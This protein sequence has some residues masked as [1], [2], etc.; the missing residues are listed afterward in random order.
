MMAGGYA[1]IENPDVI[2]P[3]WVLCIPSPEDAGN[4]LADKAAMAQ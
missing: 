1:H 3:G 4:L 2:E